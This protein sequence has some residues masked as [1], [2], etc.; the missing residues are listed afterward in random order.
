MHWC[1]QIALSRWQMYH[2]FSIIPSKQLG[3]DWNPALLTQE[4]SHLSWPHTACPAE[5]CLALCRWLLHRHC[6][7]NCLVSGYISS[8][9]A[10]LAGELSQFSLWLNVFFSHKIY[11]SMKGFRIFETLLMQAHTCVSLCLTDLGGLGVQDK[12]TQSC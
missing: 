10:Q 6:L 4:I 8:K 1:K 11:L 3:Q 12:C 7:P 9:V 2:G 5:M